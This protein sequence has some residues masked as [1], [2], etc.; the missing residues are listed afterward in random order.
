[1]IELERHREGV[2]LPVKAQPCSRRN[3]VRGE[4]DGSLKV[5]VTQV[6]EKGKANKS[7]IHQLAKS[8]GLRKSQ[9]ELL[10]GASSSEK[11]FLIREVEPLELE[12]KLNQL[13]T[14]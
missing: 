4:H 14:S 7:L 6:A 2:I 1:M 10:G 11:K 13:L 9:I 12:A 3:E 8:L 5:C